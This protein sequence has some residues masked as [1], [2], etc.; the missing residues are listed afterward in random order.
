MAGD[1]HSIGTKPI[2][3]SASVHLQSLALPLERTTEAV[4]L[5]AFPK[6]FQVDATTDWSPGLNSCHKLEYLRS[7]AIPVQ[8]NSRSIISKEP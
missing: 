2:R 8:R 4:K 7:S 1:V 5:S 3:L 6:Y